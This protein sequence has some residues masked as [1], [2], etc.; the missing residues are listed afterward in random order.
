MYTVYEVPNNIFPT[1]ADCGLMVIPLVQTIGHMEF[2]LKHEQ[3]KGLREI[4]KYPSSMCPSHSDTM[5]LVRNM[6]KQIIDFHPHAE[7]IHIGADEVKE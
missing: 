5:P 4:D 1:A 3:W 6:V 7:Y 2:V